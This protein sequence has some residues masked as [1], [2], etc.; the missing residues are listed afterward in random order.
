MV[1]C[2]YSI[3]GERESVWFVD[4]VKKYHRTFSTIFN[5]LVENGF[6]VERMLEPVP[7]MDFMRTHPD[8]RDLVHKP[9]FLLLRARKNE[10]RKNESGKNGN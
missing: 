10:A 2:R 5:T 4:N 1:L 6:T 3:E 7:S 9:A 8:E